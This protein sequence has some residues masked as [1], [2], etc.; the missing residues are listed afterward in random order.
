MKALIVTAL[1]SLSAF[2]GPK[3]SSTAVLEKMYAKYH[4]KWHTS[5]AFTQTTQRYR[6]DTVARTDTWYEHIVYPDRLRIDFGEKTGNGVIYR[7]DSS[8]VFR[9]NKVVRADKAENEL[10]FFLGGMYFKPMDEVLAHFAE[11]KF[12]LAKFHEDTYNGKPVYV[13]GADKDGEQVNQLWIDKAKLVAVRYFKYD[14]NGKEEATFEQHTAL[15]GGT[16]SETYC[17]FLI[18][19]KLLQTETYKDIVPNAVIDKAM[20]DPALLGK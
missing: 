3:L 7:G 13:L 4:G 10:I 19:D 20:F 8:Y 5:L 2:S 16:W 15:K 1:I 14:K 17:K 6:N 11:L 12:D 9:A 18:N